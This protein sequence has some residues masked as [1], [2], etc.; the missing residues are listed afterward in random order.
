M[1][2]PVAATPGTIPYLQEARQL[3]AYLIAASL[4][5]QLLP[6]FDKI[7]SALD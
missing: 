3:L 1:L 6:G 4:I 5:P 7:F 2:L